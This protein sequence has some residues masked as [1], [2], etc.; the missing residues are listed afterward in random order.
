MKV[1]NS[2]YSNSYI[3]YMNKGKLCLSQEKLKNY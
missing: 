1:E 3:V 2:I